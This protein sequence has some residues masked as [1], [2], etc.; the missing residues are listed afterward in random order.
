ML[1]LEAILVFLLG[2]IPFAVILTRAFGKDVRKVGSGNPGFANSVR[3]VGIKKAIPVL[4]AD[5]AKGY[6]G[7]VLAMAWGGGYLVAI[8]PVVGHCLS[9]FLKFRGGK[10]VATFIGVSLIISPQSAALGII[11]WLICVAITQMASVAS[12]A[13]VVVIWV[14][15]MFWEPQASLALGVGVI[16]IVLRHK[17]NIRRTMA[18]TEA[19]FK[20]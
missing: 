1:L 20:I 4:A 6:L 7:A 2:A 15:A 18:G 10:G 9:P 11:M 5:M 19:K 3:A 12:L 17:E 14:G 13:T 16:L 8:L